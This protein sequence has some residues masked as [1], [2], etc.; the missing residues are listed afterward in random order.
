[1]VK[2]AD[3]CFVPCRLLLLASFRIRL[4]FLEGN[5]RAQAITHGILNVHPMLGEGPTC[6]YDNHSS[7]ARAL[8]SK[9]KTIDLQSISCNANME[10]CWISIKPNQNYPLLG[11][12]LV[13]QKMKKDNC[14]LKSVEPHRIKNVC[15]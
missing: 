7:P 11:S 15:V 2:H 9:P 14:F 4:A 1:M 5:N 6:Q 10:I 8:E 12:Q 13:R 3:A